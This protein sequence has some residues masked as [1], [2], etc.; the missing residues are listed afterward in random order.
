MI[1]GRFSSGS[2]ILKWRYVSTI[3]LAI[4]CGDI[5]WNLCLR[6][7]RYLQFR[8]LKWPV[9]YGI[10]HLGNL[11]TF[12]DES[13]CLRRQL[14]QWNAQSAALCR[15]HG[16]RSRKGHENSHLGPQI[17]AKP[18]HLGNL[19]RHSMVSIVAEVGSMC[20]GSCETVSTLVGIC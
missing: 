5:P 15:C 11:L 19:K 3:F 13:C 16:S 2:R 18:F 6:Y 9:I 1:N 8:F 10:I 4:F 7:G 17:W 20:L 14:P 12:E